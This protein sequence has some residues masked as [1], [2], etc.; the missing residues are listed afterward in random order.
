ML[1]FAIHGGRN[2]GVFD[3]E[4][5]RVRAYGGFLMFVVAIFGGA[6]L[7]RLLVLQ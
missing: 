4:R 7:Y 3:R 2:G 1:A 5:G 6:L